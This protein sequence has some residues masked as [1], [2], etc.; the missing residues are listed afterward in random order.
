VRVIRDGITK[1]IEAEDLVPGDIMVLS[2]G[3]HISADGRLIEASELRID[4][5][6]LTGESHPVKKIADPWY[7]SGFSKIEYPNLVFAGTSVAS[8]TGL[9]VVIATGMNT[10]FG[11]VADLTQGIEE[12]KSPL[13]QEMVHVTR[14]RNDSCGEYWYLV[15][16]HAYN[17]HISHA[18]IQFYFCTWYDSGIC[19]RR[20]ITNRN[21]RPSPG[22]TADGETKCSHK[23][24]IC[25]RDTGMYICYLY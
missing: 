4:Q 1:N 24:I 20:T 2:E 13:Q 6:T 15:F 18:C 11:K 25:C 17:S 7:D 3:D 23:T 16:F 22:V 19:P 21:S 14:T 8:G 9:A 12:E 10:E 5:S